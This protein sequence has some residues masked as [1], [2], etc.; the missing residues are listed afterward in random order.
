MFNIVLISPEHPGNVGNIS[1]TCV[2]TESRLHLV[3]PFKFD[4]SNKSLKK[5][6]IDYWDKLDLVVHDSLE[7]FFSYV[8][9]KNIYLIETGSN[10]NYADISYKDG[11]F[12]IFGREKEGID[13]KILEK[14]KE[15]IR[16][17]SYN[18]DLKE[19][20]EIFNSEFDNNIYSK[21]TKSAIIAV[22]LLI[23]TLL[24]FV[25]IKYKYSSIIGLIS[26]LIST[27]CISYKLYNEIKYINDIDN[28]EINKGK[29]LIRIFFKNEKINV[30][31]NEGINYIEF[32]INNSEKVEIEES[33]KIEFINS[34]LDSKSFYYIKLSFSVLLG[35]FLM[36]I[37]ENNINYS[38]IIYIID[39][40][41]LLALL[42]NNTA[43]L[44]LIKYRNID[45]QKNKKLIKES[46]NSLKGDILLD[47]L[48]EKSS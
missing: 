22:I 19:I 44:L 38:N 30:D 47:S 26:L 39:L 46:L 6:G 1:R 14:Y 33:A 24:S 29:E 41:L 23:F 27:I 34:L 43:S 3:R 36:K 35:S 20:F 21:G 15:K 10:K 12:F 25:F 45:F 48:K 2:L 11:D 28:K 7:E 5:A 4:F 37:F 31:S 40:F 16:V 17:K 32:L 13:K 9:N 8:K 42:I 18:K